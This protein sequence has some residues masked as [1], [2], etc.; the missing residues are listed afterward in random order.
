MYLRERGDR[1]IALAFQGV[2]ESYQS[3]KQSAGAAESPAFLL[4]KR[5]PR[6]ETSVASTG[7]EVMKLQ[8]LWPLR[9]WTKFANWRHR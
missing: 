2:I 7:S 9:A 4:E 5:V 3:G 6:L 8:N 1:D